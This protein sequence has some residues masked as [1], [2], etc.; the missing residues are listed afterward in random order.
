MTSSV[1][2]ETETEDCCDSCCEQCCGGCDDCNPPEDSKPC[3][4]EECCPSD[5]DECGC[6]DCPVCC[7]DE[8]QHFGYQ[9]RKQ[10]QDVVDK[11]QAAGFEFV[12]E[13][14]FRAVYMRKGIVVKVPHN[15]DGYIDNR[16]EAHAWRIYR[17][18]ATSLGIFLAP[19]RLLSNGCLMMV[20]VDTGDKRAYEDLPDWALKVDCSQVGIYKERLVAYDYALELVERAEWEKEWG[21]TSRFFHC[22]RLPYLRKLSEGGAE[23]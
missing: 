2:N 1:Q 21:T 7:G 20:T 9:E 12:G 4:C 16:T 17:D 14:M 18:K 6:G 8:V 3:E 23:T 11:L 10:M 22:N 19:C 15:K 13:G 5:D